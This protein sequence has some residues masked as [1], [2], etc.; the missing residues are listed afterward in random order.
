M[1]PEL[2]R[3]ESISEQV[4]GLRGFISGVQL[5]IVHPLVI[6]LP[7][8]DTQPKVPR[9]LQKLL[10]Q[11]PRAFSLRTVKAQRRTMEEAKRTSAKP[12]SERGLPTLGGLSAFATQLFDLSPVQAWQP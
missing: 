3:I 10:R 9:A 2:G 6:G 4:S 7:I 12:P 1:T 11:L 5:T 8:L